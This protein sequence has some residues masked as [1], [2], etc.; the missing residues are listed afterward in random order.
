[1]VNNERKP[2][3]NAMTTAR[4]T[5]VTPARSKVKEPRPWKLI[6]GTS[7]A[8]VLLLSGSVWAWRHY[9]HLARL[10]RAG[11]L[12]ATAVKTRAGQP[13][14]SPQ[15]RFGLDDNTRQAIDNLGLTQAER[16]EL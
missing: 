10:R 7:I 5:R 16:D 14:S 12:I 15:R 3:M 4:T 11:Q 8:A 6:L 2:I 1:M 13:G 9:S